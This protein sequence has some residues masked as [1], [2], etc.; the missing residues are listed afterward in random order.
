MGKAEEEQARCALKNQP[1]LSRNL[2]LPDRLKSTERAETDGDFFPFGNPEEMSP[3]ES[4][5]IPREH[6]E[7]GTVY[8]DADD[9]SLKTDSENS[10]DKNPATGACESTVRVTSPE[11][12]ENDSSEDQN[13][14]EDGEHDARASEIPESSDENDDNFKYP[15]LSLESTS[16]NDLMALPN[17]NFTGSPPSMISATTATAATALR[18]IEPFPQGTSLPQL[19][20]G[21]ILNTAAP[22]SISSKS[23]SIIETNFNPYLRLNDE[24]SDSMESIISF[25]S[26]T[27]SQAMLP[28]SGSA[29][30]TLVLLQRICNFGKNVFTIM[31]PSENFNSSSASNLN[32]NNN[33]KLKHL[34]KSAFDPPQQS[35]LEISLDSSFHQLSGG[36]G[37]KRSTV[38]PNT[39]HQRYDAN[40]PQSRSPPLEDSHDR[41]SPE[42]SRES[43]PY[44]LSNNEHSVRT[45]SQPEPPPIDVKECNGDLRE[46]CPDFNALKFKLSL[47]LRLFK[48]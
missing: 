45:S 1:T 30:D 24:F 3:G 12:I 18:E 47:H 43:E 36:Q 48:V 31:L 19:M 7:G 37:E 22:P 17:M 46:P 9:V 14:Y 34:Q 41:Q 21:Y 15:P 23:P 20:P 8:L 42:T 40:V 4:V 13:E 35:Q 28:I 39:Q 26:P 27:I 25:P 6:N 2:S 16:A 10:V 5:S 38:T 11:K 29:V 44:G 32:S 33:D